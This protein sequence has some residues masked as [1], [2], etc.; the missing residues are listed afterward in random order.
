M[1][2]SRSVY[3]DVRLEAMRNWSEPTVTSSRK[4]TA[5][6]SSCYG[7]DYASIHRWIVKSALKNP[8]SKRRY[9]IR[10]ERREKRKIGGIEGRK[11][12][13]GKKIGLER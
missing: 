8:S 13:G 10:E 1:V 4:A 5:R 9:K 7:E 6:I 3:M 11:A 2:Y 12:T